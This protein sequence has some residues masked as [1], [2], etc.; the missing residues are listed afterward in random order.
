MHDGV[1]DAEDENEGACELMEVDVLVQR[2]YDGEATRAHERYA[3]AQH[4]H[5]HEHAIEVET[6]P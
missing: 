5:Q 2:K 4:Q 1:D 6:L 3:L